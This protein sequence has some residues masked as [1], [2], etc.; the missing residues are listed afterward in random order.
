[1]KKIATIIFTLML[2]WSG[3][4]AQS[5]EDGKKLLSYQKNKS[6]VDLFQQLYNKNTNSAEHIYWYGQSLIA[7]K[8]YAEAKAL[9]QKALQAGVN[10]PLIW[11]GAGHIELIEKGDLNSAK[12][13]FEQAITASTPTKGR[14]KHKPDPSI[15]NAIGRAN[16]YGDSKMGDPNYGIEKL[17][18]ASEIDLKDAEILVNMGK[19]YQK[20]GG[21]MGGDAVKAYTEATVRDP[22]YAE[23]NWRMGLIYYSQDNKDMYEKYY[24]AAIASDIE[25]PPVYLS[26]YR[27]Y[28][29]TNVNVAKEYLDKYMQ[30]ADKD[31]GT[32]YFYADYLFRAGKY[33]ESLNKAIEMSNSNCKNF[34]RLPILFAY[35]YD[36]LGDSINAK[37]FI[38][39][40]FATTNTADIEATDYELAVKV[41]SK[42]EGVE[43]QTVAFLQKAIDNDSKKENK[44]KYT[45]MAA[46]IYGKAKMYKEHVQWLHKYND[47]KGSMGEYDYYVI[48]NSSFQSKD[49]V[50]TMV[51]AQKYIAAFPNKPQGYAY[52]VAAAKA[53]D[54]SSTICFAEPAILQY[55]DF[56]LKDST[57]NKSQIV[58]NYY[59]IMIYY[60]DK[61]KD[62]S[63]ALEYCNKILLIIP[64]D[65]EM[66]D[67]KK[68]LE[69]RAAKSPKSTK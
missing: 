8:N 64:D 63:K 62:Y 61:I 12:Q 3:I 35:N 40:F 52:N 68:V 42:F 53:L 29:Q 54:T 25:F 66:L 1:M 38:D 45:K 13:K 60:A 69:E 33:Q 4:N 28:E 51:L 55:N 15:L 9:Y 31:C 24:N 37:K 58:S 22:K 7:N 20:L 14:N 67:I 17:R 6:A 49:Y 26:Y 43:N 18:Q 2:V 65:K 41:F 30:Y 59:Y 19:C 27:V 39:Q 5:I 11:I 23:A 46:D 21:E 36:R 16:A 10:E 47:L 44:L 48:T 57:T 32:D 50:G 34:E 56:L